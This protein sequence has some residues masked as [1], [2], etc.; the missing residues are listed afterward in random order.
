MWR[1][2]RPL[3]A[4]AFALGAGIRYRRYGP[5]FPSNQPTRYAFNGTEMDRE[6]TTRGQRNGMFAGAVGGGKRR[7]GRARG[8]GSGRTKRARNGSQS[9]AHNPIKLAK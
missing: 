7:P 2:S 1:V 3:P 9:H 8:R 6:L 4:A 5:H